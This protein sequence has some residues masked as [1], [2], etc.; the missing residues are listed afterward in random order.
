[1]SKN[2]ES[3]TD[4]AVLSLSRAA[5]LSLLTH[6]WRHKNKVGWTGGRRTDHFPFTLRRSV[7]VGRVARSPADPENLHSIWKS[8]IFSN[9]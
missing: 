3:I 1:M 8:V 9:S 5:A 6:S 2:P 4:A 7:A